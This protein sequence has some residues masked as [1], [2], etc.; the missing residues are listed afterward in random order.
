MQFDCVQIVSAMICAE[1]RRLRGGI[2]FAD[3]LAKEIA[4]FLRERYAF[5]KMPSRA[6]MLMVEREDQ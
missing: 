4:P 1:I 3:S 6:F 2:R 5:S